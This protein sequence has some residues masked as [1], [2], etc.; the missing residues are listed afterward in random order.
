MLP[1]NVKAVAFDPTAAQ[2]VLDGHD[3]AVRFLLLGSIVLGVD[4]LVPSNVSVIP[5][6]PTAAQKVRVGHDTDV[7][8]LVGSMFFATDQPAPSNVSTAPWSPTAAQ[9]VLV[10]HDTESRARLLGST[11]LGAAQLV[12]LNVSADP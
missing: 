9:N 2:N 10:G 12:P 8:T 4:H 1:W 7:S 5:R 6:S 3:T 11:V